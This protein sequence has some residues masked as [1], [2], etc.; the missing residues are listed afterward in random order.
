MFMLIPIPIRIP[1]PIHIHIHIPVNVTAGKG[2]LAFS[3][4]FSQALKFREL[5][6]ASLDHLVNIEIRDL[7][8]LVARKRM[9]WMN[10]K[11]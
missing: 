6:I 5:S 4:P 9:D 10:R 8:Q 1:M 7:N 2:K 3:F 11:S